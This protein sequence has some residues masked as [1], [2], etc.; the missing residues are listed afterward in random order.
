MYRL[1]VIS[2]YSIGII[3]VSM[4]LILVLNPYV[5]L[6]YN[7]GKGQCFSK[8]LVSTGRNNSPEKYG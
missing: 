3:Y 5:D 8:C 1:Y 4:I 7:R 2:Q 6:P